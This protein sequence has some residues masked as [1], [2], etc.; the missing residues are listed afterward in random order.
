ME[1]VDSP[2]TRWYKI[3][4]VY[5]VFT[6]LVLLF[7]MLAQEVMEAETLGFDTAVLTMIHKIANPTLNGLFLGVTNLAGA[8]FIGIITIALAVGFYMRHEIY[9]SLYILLTLGGTIFL[10][11]TLKIFFKR[12]R[13]DLWSLLVVEKS[14]SFP[15]GHAMISMALAL[16]LIVLTYYSRARWFSIILGA[17]YVVLIG[18]S[19]LYLGVH[20]PTDI[21]GGWLISSVWILLA[22]RLM[23]HNRAFRT[24]TLT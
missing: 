15:S 4:I 6:G 10:N 23:F 18:F 20:F 22:T 7:T 5:V 21:L 16:T 12:T 14:Y 17:F 3:G 19:R 11:T 24:D 13:P 2:K 1:K 8:V 9:N